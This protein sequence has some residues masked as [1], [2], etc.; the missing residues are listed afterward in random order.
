M[1]S[2]NLETGLYLT[3]ARS[4]FCSEIPVNWATTMERK[5]ADLLPSAC[6][7]AIPYTERR[8]ML[9]IYGDAP[10]TVSDSIVTKALEILDG[11]AGKLFGN[12]GRLYVNVVAS[13]ID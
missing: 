13:T 5:P 11:V 4:S 1:P 8:E 9:K 12:V 3:N 7:P 10:V 2:Y 6:I